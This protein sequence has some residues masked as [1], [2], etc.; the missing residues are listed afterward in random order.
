MYVSN[1]ATAVCMYVCMY[2]KNVDINVFECMYVCM[3]DS[4]SPELWSIAWSARPV[5][6]AGRSHIHPARAL[7]ENAPSYPGEAALPNA[8]T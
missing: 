4:D 2:C 5:G 6:L 1:N 7:C 3:Y 8:D